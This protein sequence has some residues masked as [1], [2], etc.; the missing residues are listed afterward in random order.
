MSL[1]KHPLVLD[2]TYIRCS[3]TRAELRARTTLCVHFDEGALS[4]VPVLFSGDTLFQHSIGR[5]DLWG[6][7]FKLLLKSIRQRLFTLD[8]QTFV[9]PGHG[10]STEMGREAHSNPFLTG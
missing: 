2:G 5:T 7:D 3:N 1:V 4:D 10:P 9:M 6:G 8:D